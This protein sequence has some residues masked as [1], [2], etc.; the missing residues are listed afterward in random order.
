MSLPSGASGDVPSAPEDARVRGALSHMD[1]PRVRAGV[2]LGSEV[3]RALGEFFHREGFVEIAPVLVAPVTDPLNH[4]VADPTVDY[5]GQPFQ[6]TRSMIFHKQLAMRAFPR[7]FVFSPNLRFEPRER[8]STGRHLVEFT[9]VDV[10][11]RDADREEVMT[12][13]ERALTHVVD[14]LAQHA[15]GT[16]AQLGRR[17]P[18]LSPPFPR[19]DW[20]AARAEHGP[21]FE[22]ALSRESPT[23]FWLV[24]IPLPE[25]EFYDREDPARPGVLRDMDLIYPEGY[26]EALSGGEREFEL[27]AILRRIHAKGQSVEQFRWYVEAAQAGLPP[28]AGFGIG[29][30]RLVRWLGGLSDVAETSLF[31]KRIGTWSL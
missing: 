12:L 31:P 20:R 7:V 29:V 21:E 26:G 23:P 2:R 6:L 5:Y 28:S 9:Q 16:L 18:V 19:R 27:P 8:S 1:H 10:E 14:H 24:D 11:V 4:P 13:A 30:E 3:R 15:R 17:L 25:R 22:M